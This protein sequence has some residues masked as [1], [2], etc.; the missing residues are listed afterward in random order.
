MSKVILFDVGNTN[1]VLACYENGTK[2]FT[3]RLLTY[4]H[5]NQD[6]LTGAIASLL[7]A[8]GVDGE[9]IEGS[10]IAT[11]VPKL[12]PL[13]KTAMEQIC[14]CVSFVAQRDLIG[15]PTDDYDTSCLGVDRLVDVLAASHKYGAP[16]VVCD[17]G[18]CS[19]FSIM[20]SEGAFIGGMISAGIQ[21]SLDSE[22]ARTAQLPQIKAFSPDKLIGCDTVSC[23]I[24]GEVIGT[25][26]MIDG[27][28]ERV[29]ENLACNREASGGW[30]LVITGGL[31]TLVMPWLKSRAYYEPDLQ[32][33]GLEILYQKSKIQ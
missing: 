14:G 29:C 20:D 17:L 18:T 13:L 4:N 31:G 23:M 26:A 30:K 19:T 5:W 22:A 11:V 15:I 10:M 9:N 25:A 33:D 24:S 32:L 21:L 27:I 2:E 7:Q 3:E 12:I 8:H 6:D 16:V 28:F 1:I